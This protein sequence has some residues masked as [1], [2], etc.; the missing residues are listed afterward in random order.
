LY[1]LWNLSANGLNARDYERCYRYAGQL[2]ESARQAHDLVW[3]AAALRL[4]GMAYQRQFRIDEARQSLQTALGLY[5]QAQKLVGCALTLET[6][7]H[8]EISLGNY[9]AAIQNYQQAYKL[10]EQV[11]DLHNMAGATINMSCAASFQG[12]YAAEKE[13][14]RRAVLQ[15][16]Q[17]QEQFYEAIA[18][19][20]LGEAEREL[21][22]LDS[23]RGHL[24]EAL[25]LLEDDS[26]LL[27]R[28]SV[29]T[30][31]ALI[32]WKAGDFPS[33]LQTAEVI[34]AAYP[35][36]DGK[37]D[38][39]HRFLWTAARILHADGQAGRAA[40]ALAQAYAT[41]QRDMSAIPEAEARR[42]Y[43]EI[44]HNR[45]IVAAHERGEWG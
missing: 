40:Q 16:Q 13:Y 15:S 27:E 17:V 43:A 9:D 5:R 24:T 39:V 10:S 33:A 31:L 6:L 34:L 35:K 41:F 37:D 7:G 19:Q 18:L 28:V 32:F 30:D 12:D 8:V 21:G 38:N 36:V 2:L 29:Q 26:L 22:D 44:R 45:E 14:A 42:S 4:M 1:A 11:G 23:A 20:N 25:S 3:Q